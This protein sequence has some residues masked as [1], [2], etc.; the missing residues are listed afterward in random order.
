MISMMTMMLMT[1]EGWARGRG[2]GEPEGQS[3][4]KTFP[5]LIQRGEGSTCDWPAAVSNGLALINPAR[6]AARQCNVLGSAQSL[7]ML[8]TLAESITCSR[9]RLPGVHLCWQRGRSPLRV[10]GVHSRSPFMLATRP[11]SITCSRS[12]FPESISE[13][14]RLA[15]SIHRDVSPLKF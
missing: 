13:L 1:R 4:V 11:E 12:P 15:E 2:P 9:S 5:R 10:R 6:H 14:A 3:Q 7:F 8:A